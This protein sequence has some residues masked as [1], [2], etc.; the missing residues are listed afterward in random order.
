[1]KTGKL[2][3]KLTL[4]ISKKRGK[5][6]FP[7]QNNGCGWELRRQS[8]FFFLNNYVPD[9]CLHQLQFNKSKIVTIGKE[10][11]MS[12]GLGT[13]SIQQLFGGDL[14]QNMI[15][16]ISKLILFSSYHTDVKS[17][18]CLRAAKAIFTQPY[19]KHSTTCFLLFLFHMYECF[20][21]M[22]VQ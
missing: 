8:L 10:F 19:Q 11:D 21:Q 20:A 4:R 2:H 5:Q 1:M 6:R 17:P 22:Y 3:V 9:I 16:L 13:F 14:Y 15:F 12:K 7:L 18:V